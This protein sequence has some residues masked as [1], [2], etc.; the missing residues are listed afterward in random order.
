MNQGNE[1]TQ[2]SHI[3]RSHCASSARRQNICCEGQRQGPTVIVNTGTLTSDAQVCSQGSE[4]DPL[5]LNIFYLFQKHK[6]DK[7][8]QYFNVTWTPSSKSPL[9]S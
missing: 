6:H 8:A 7:I 3:L 5:N 4:R 2:V 9:L 1:D